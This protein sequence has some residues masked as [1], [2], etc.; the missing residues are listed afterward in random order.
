MVAARP[1]AAILPINIEVFYSSGRFAAN[2]DSRSITPIWQ[3]LLLAL[4]PVIAVSLLL[5]EEDQPWKDLAL[6]LSTGV[7]AAGIWWSAFARYAEAEARKVLGEEL[8]KQRAVMQS[9]LVRVRDMLTNEIAFESR[10][11]RELRLP[12]TVYPAAEGFDL[13]FNKDL[14]ED[15]RRSRF[16]YFS[17]PSG[18]YVPAR[19]KLR[20][21]EA[22]IRLEEVFIRMID[23]LSPLAMKRAIADRKRRIVHAHKTDKEIEQEIK[24]DLALAHAALWDVRHQVHGPIRISYADEAIVRRVEVFEDGA[25][26]SS[27][28]HEDKEAFPPTA[29]WNPRQ[30]T[31]EQARGEFSTHSFT[32]FTITPHTPEAAV[33]DQVIN[34]LELEMD[35]V[36]SYLERYAQKYLRWM[37]EGLAKAMDH[38]DVVHLSAIRGDGDD[39]NA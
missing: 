12:R 29:A 36:Q 18:V 39:A 1:P 6:A 30:T 5:G 34:E 32:G 24:A 28:D 38:V 19:I 27:I 14:T 16:Y 33:E 3:Y 4:L 11:W 13:R 7:A 17:G 2:L 21:N 25:Y 26:D 20:S 23:P 10:R 15:L 37:E 9:E 31:W 22:S 8:E 35:S